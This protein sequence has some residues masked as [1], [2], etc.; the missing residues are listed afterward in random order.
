MKSIAIIALL[1]PVGAMAQA[2]FSLPAG[3]TAFLTVQEASCTV[4]HHFL[5]EGDPEGT[6]RRVS[7]DEDRMTYMGQIDAETQWIESYHP[8]SGHTERLE[9]H[10]AE[11]ASFSDLI[12]NKI[13]VYDFRTS[14][15]EVGTTRYVGKDILTGRVVTIDDVPLEETRFEITALA[16]DG[17]LLWRSEGHEF[18][19][20]D[21]RLFLSGTAMITNTT[22]T[23][24]T[25]NTPKEFIFPGEAGFLSSKPK[26]GCGVVMSA[27]PELQEFS[28][29]NI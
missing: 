12:T 14:S 19:N 6:R 20:R 23:F 22:E 11:P 26:Y 3:C 13:D 15:S 16:P 21:W 28:N 17:T 4:D 18:I 25:D 10:P 24:E 9:S 27:V 8:L 7:L 5:C 1:A 2:P 29:D